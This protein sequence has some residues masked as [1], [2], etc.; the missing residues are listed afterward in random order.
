MTPTPQ[1]TPSPILQGASTSRALRLALVG[2]VATTAGACASAATRTSNAQLLAPPA[3]SCI[4]ARENAAL[5]PRLDVE[6]VPTPVR[7]V[8][9]PIR[10]PVP[11]SA[12]RRDGSSVLK[13]EVLVD[14][15]GKP[16]MTTFRAIESTSAWLTTGA[17]NAIAQWTFEPA[18]LNGCKVPRYYQFAASSPPRRR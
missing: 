3:D 2:L 10:R 7:M 8:P 5:D 6:R 9:A 15:L 14:T 13:V 12:I 18:L 16:D 4:I 17:R 1:P 11:P